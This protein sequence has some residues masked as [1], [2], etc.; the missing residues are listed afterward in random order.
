VPAG[1]PAAAAQRLGA[2]FGHYQGKRYRNLA[3]VASALAVLAEHE[4]AYLPAAL[5]SGA[6]P[7][8]PQ[9]GDALEL[10]L[11][12]WRCCMNPTRAPLPAGRG[13]LQ[14]AAGRTPGRPVHAGGRSATAIWPMA[15]ASKRG[16]PASTA[17][18]IRFI[19]GSTVSH[20][21]L[22]WLFIP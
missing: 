18:R 17:G 14:G 2:A 12:R 19:A 5:C 7:P 3:G 13:P 4:C 1:L 6:P 10:A 22:Q 15:S 9:A 16:N 8:P 20:G 11:E 21:P